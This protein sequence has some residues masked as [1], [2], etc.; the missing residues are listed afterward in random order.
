MRRKEAYC[1]I[2]SQMIMTGCE[3]GSGLC[4]TCLKTHKDICPKGLKARSLKEFKE[5]YFLNVLFKMRQIEQYKS[6]LKEDQEK[7][8]QHF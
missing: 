8:A 2:H 3:C 7:Y 6:K 5:E 1:G 4:S